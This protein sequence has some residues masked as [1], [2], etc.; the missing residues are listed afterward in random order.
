MS[1]VI[2]TLGDMEIIDVSQ[3]QIDAQNVI[4][5]RHSYWWSRWCAQPEIEESDITAEITYIAEQTNFPTEKILPI[6][7]IHTRKCR[8]FGSY[9][10][11]LRNW[12]KLLD[13]MEK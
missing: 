4:R 12:F 11:A 9:P 2:G 1:T 3:D 13:L 8:D 6:L 5:L 10:I 7:L